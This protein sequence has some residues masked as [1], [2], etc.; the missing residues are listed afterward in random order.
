MND[1]IAAIALHSILKNVYNYNDLW[2]F[3]LVCHSE[4]SLEIRNVTG[5]KYILVI[6]NKRYLLSQWHKIIFSKW[7][8]YVWYKPRKGCIRILKIT[9]PRLWHWEAGIWEQ[10]C[11]GR[12]S[13]CPEQ[14]WEG[15]RQKERCQREPH[16]P[17]WGGFLLRAGTRGL[18]WTA[19][20]TSQGTSLQP[21]PPLKSDG[22]IKAKV[23]VQGNLY[24]SRHDTSSSFTLRGFK[25]FLF[26]R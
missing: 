3:S 22:H 2:Q 16:P 19:P 5:F 23:K 26:A 13:L 9:F 4:Y 10:K 15:C 6:H 7:I 25:A 11:L 18:L 14:P 12:I 17:P 24:L 1:I 21:A 20:V 8:I